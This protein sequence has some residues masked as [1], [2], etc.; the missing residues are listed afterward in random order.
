[1]TCSLRELFSSTKGTYGR[2]WFDV[3]WHDFHLQN[4]FDYDGDKKVDLL[5]KDEF[6]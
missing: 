6:G 1:M 2:L 3:V 5:L 4:D